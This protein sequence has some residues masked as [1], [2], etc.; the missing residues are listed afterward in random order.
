MPY[1]R[2]TGRRGEGGLYMKYPLENAPTTEDTQIMYADIFSTQR[3]LSYAMNPLKASSSS[4]RLQRL[5]I[6][7]KQMKVSRR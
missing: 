3:L 7:S 4:Q 5:M 1:S 2:G 6:H